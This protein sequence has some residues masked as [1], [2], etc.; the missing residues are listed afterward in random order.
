M[1]NV[2]SLLYMFDRPNKA[3]E[4]TKPKVFYN[5]GPEAATSENNQAGIK[6][7]TEL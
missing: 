7:H 3:R 6:I 1:L 5:I 4:I 2:V